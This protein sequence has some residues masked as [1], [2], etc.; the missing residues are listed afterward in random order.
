MTYSGSIYFL[1]A[2]RPAYFEANDLVSL[3]IKMHAAASQM[4][5]AEWFEA[6]ITEA[7]QT[8]KRKDSTTSISIEHGARGVSM[9][10]S[11]HDPWLDKLTTV[12]PACP[13]LDYSAV[14]NQ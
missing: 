10:R 3:S 1:G 6:R 5:E 4:P 13:G 7:F 8:L 12:M 14:V 2:Y 9:S 11:S